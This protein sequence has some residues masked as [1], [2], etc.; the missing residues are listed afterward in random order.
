MKT[1]IM[2]IVLAGV[3]TAV[4]AQGLSARTGIEGEGTT[5]RSILRIESFESIRTLSK[6]E[7]R[8]ESRFSVNSL[9]E[10]N[11]LSKF[12]LDFSNVEEITLKDGTVVKIEDIQRKIDS[13]WGL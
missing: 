10:R 13:D 8:S 6:E 3:S 1:F 9:A 5:G 11:A 12:A 7:L 4:S 2:M